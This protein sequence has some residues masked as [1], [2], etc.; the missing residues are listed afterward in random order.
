MS[1]LEL[2][3]AVDDFWQAFAPQWRQT[4][5]QAGAIKRMRAGYLS[6]S[7]VMTLIIHFHQAHY[8]DFKAYYT[9]YVL[10][11]LRPEFPTL[12]SYPRFIA[13]IPSVLV[14]LCAYLEQCRGNCSG[15]SF[16][17]STPIAVCHNRRIT[18]HRVFAGLAQRG[19]NSVGWFYAGPFKR[20]YRNCQA[21]TRSTSTARPTLLGSNGSW[22]FRR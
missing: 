14:P 20:S 5:L 3:C 11:Y 15:L 10:T 8:R 7:E 1:L 4:Q 6:E 13:L 17:D 9:R 2:F 12:V 18:R 16:V 21:L 22:V 19:K